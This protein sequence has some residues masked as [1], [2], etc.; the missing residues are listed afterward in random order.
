MVQV[1]SWSQQ[2]WPDACKLSEQ[3]Q[4]SPLS[5]AA[6]QEDCGSAAVA[7]V[8]ASISQMPDSRKRMNRAF[9]IMIFI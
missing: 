2:S 4:G 7:T 1:Q 6:Q 8:F 3:W 9:L 5:I